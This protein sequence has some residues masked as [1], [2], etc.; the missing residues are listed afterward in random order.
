VALDQREYKMYTSQDFKL[1]KDFKIY[2]LE[3]GYFLYEV[4]YP[5]TDLK[6]L[7]KNR[8]Q[9]QFFITNEKQNFQHIVSWIHLAIKM[10][11][12]YSS[13]TELLLAERVM[14]HKDAKELNFKL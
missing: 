3:D 9:V 4:E 14:N 12:L 8:D 10:A 11:P 1:C 2:E 13:A 6:R 7:N 5:V